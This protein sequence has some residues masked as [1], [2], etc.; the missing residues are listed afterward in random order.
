[1]TPGG[2]GQD[3]RDAS[4]SF[5][6]L[7]WYLRERLQV[8]APKSHHVPSVCAKLLQLCPT[9]CDPIDCSLPWDSLG[10][11]TGLGCHFLL[12]RIFL[13][14]GSKPRS[15]AVIGGFF[16]TSAT[17]KAPVSP[18]PTSNVLRCCCSV[19][20][21]CTILF[22]L[23]DRS[24]PGFPVLHCLLEFAQTHVHCCHP[25]ISSSVTPCSF[26]PQSFAASGRVFSNE[27]A[28]CI[29]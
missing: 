10:K 19:A 15:P 5:I 12:Q 18:V 28:L 8:A 13:T 4:P 7:C 27:S 17:W 20:K 23:M 11:N 9:L 3:F 21:S 24:M 6:H 22:D 2:V 1:M 25:A 16:T 29:R 14:Q 26:C